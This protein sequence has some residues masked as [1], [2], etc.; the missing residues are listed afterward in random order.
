MAVQVEVVGGQLGHP[1][2]GLLTLLL[3]GPCV[4]LL[5]R[6]LHQRPLQTGNDLAL[7]V[8]VLER[9]ETLHVTMDTHFF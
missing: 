3:D 1:Q 7:R 6:L 5:L 9:A 2:D 4:L 8:D